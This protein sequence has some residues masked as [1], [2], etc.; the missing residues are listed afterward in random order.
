[1]CLLDAELRRHGLATIADRLGRAP[2]GV[3]DPL[4]LDRAVDRF[5]KGK[6]KLV[7]LCAVY[8]V[9]ESGDLHTAD[10]DVIATL[11]VLQAMARRHTSLSG[12]SLAELHAYQVDA[13]RAWAT[14]FNDWR[15]SRGLD[16]PG[17]G[18]DWLVDER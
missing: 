6:R 9:N 5:R 11:D 8:G 13:H 18:L 16:G 17:A 2:V 4:V 14:S 1:M 10:V 12:M 15:A 7:D 3:I